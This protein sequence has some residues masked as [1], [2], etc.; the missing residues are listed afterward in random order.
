MTDRE[1]F[2]R[3]KEV[4]IAKA[5][6]PPI[7]EKLD[8][9]IRQH[10]KVWLKELMEVRPDYNR[11]TSVNGV[12]DV[13]YRLLDDA[14]HKAVYAQVGIR[15]SGS[16]FEAVNYHGTAN[17]YAEIKSHAARLS[18]A[19]TTRLFDEM[20]AKFTVEN[21]PKK[22]LDGAIKSYE[23]V[24][25]REFDDSVAKLAKT[26]ARIDAAKV[27]TERLGMKVRAVEPLNHYDRGFE[28]D[29]RVEVAEEDE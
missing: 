24:Y 17:I 25:K 4:E 16:D 28:I 29:E 1:L 22:I 7:L 26:H 10:S 13:V 19:I 20:R 2:A 18:T 27:F 8:A 11:S 14:L 15:R 9:R 3:E 12:Q 5:K 23:E 21:L 6:E